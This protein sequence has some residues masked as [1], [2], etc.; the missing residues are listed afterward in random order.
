MSIVSEQPPKDIE[1]NERPLFVR[2]MYLI[3]LCPVHHVQMR[4]VGQNKGGGTLRYY[5]CNVVG[6]ACKG[7]GT[8]QKFY[9]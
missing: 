9:S 6:C 7:R 3:P 1:P 2:V 5:R 8:V 4:R